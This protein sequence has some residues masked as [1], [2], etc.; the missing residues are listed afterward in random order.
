[1][2]ILLT[3]IR[4]KKVLNYFILLYLMKIINKKLYFSKLI[5]IYLGSIT[6][7]LLKQSKEIQYKDIIII[8]F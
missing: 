5:Q 2:I 4:K 1:M 8:N 6:I 3:Y 7:I